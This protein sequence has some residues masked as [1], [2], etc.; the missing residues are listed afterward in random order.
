MPK[1]PS[2]TSSEVARLIRGALE[3]GWAWGSFKVVAEGGRL[4]LIPIAGGEGHP[5]DLD[6]ELAEWDRTHGHGT[7]T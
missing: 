5:D 7:P 2:F 6:A 3:A 1:R 4:A